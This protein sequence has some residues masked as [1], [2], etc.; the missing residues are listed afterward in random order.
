MESEKMTAKDLFGLEIMPNR[1]CLWQSR[2]HYY[3][4]V[5]VEKDR[6]TPVILERSDF[7]AVLKKIHKQYFG[8]IQYCDEEEPEPQ[9][10]SRPRQQ[11]CVFYVAFCHRLSSC[12]LSTYTDPLLNKFNFFHNLIISDLKKFFNVILSPST[13]LLQESI[14]F[15]IPKPYCQWYDNCIFMDPD[16]KQYMS[17]NE[18]MIMIRRASNYFWNNYLAFRFIGVRTSRNFKQPVV[19]CS[20]TGKCYVITLSTLYNRIH[21]YVHNVWMNT[22]YVSKSFLLPGIVE[23]FDSLCSD[24][25]DI[26]KPLVLYVDNSG[27]FRA[28]QN[29]E[30]HFIAA[31]LN[32]IHK[33]FV[34]REWEMINEMLTVAKSKPFSAIPKDAPGFSMKLKSKIMMDSNNLTDKL[35][36]NKYVIGTKEMVSLLYTEKGYTNSSPIEFIFSNDALVAS[37]KKPRI[38][39]S[40]R[41][42]TESTSF[43]SRKLMSFQEETILIDN[44]ENVSGFIYE[45]CDW[46]PEE[47]ATTGCGKPYNSFTT[48]C[49]II[50]IVGILLLVGLL[51]GHSHC[52]NSTET[53]LN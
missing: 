52:K 15:E 36:T 34:K 47:F 29:F 41:K 39:R 53:S 8:K 46:E 50:S 3:A 4:I 44:R 31:S 6:Y 19:I 45:L 18:E 21:N 30:D 33:H 9:N 5:F 28:Q 48:I 10:I 23:V 51:L 2:I 16:S 32:S 11:E 40:T 17:N 37:P 12:I 24:N 7:L 49:I 42:L 38:R 43:G 14:S 20:G 22:S 26:C 27:M 1:V 13:E 25:Q 35:K